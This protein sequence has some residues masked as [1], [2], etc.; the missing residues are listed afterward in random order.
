MLVMTAIVTA[1]STLIF[2]KLFI[3]P[4]QII[5]VRPSPSPTSPSSFS[6]ETLVSPP[7]VPISTAIRN[8]LTGKQTGAVQIV[9]SDTVK[10]APQTEVKDQ[11]V[12]VN[13]SRSR[14]SSAPTSSSGSPPFKGD[15][16][17]SRPIR[18]RMDQRDRLT[19]YFGRRGSKT[20]AAAS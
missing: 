8:L 14:S 9:E 16:T 13:K 18:P 17:A 11:Q 1:L 10:E 3:T 20:P 5:I 12:E 2:V 6:I 4:Q 7:A 15:L 19:S